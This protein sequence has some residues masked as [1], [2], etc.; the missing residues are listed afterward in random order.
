MFLPGNSWPKTEDV[1]DKHIAFAFAKR[2]KYGYRQ[3]QG[4]SWDQYGDSS[5]AA[6]ASASA[7]ESGRGMRSKSEGLRS[8]RYSQPTE[9]TTLG[10]TGPVKSGIRNL[11]SILRDGMRQ[12][13]A[14]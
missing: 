2:K 10:R 7:E 4:N 12:P 9:D 6:S 5:S 13:A 14:C 1:L 3:E 11:T 8:M